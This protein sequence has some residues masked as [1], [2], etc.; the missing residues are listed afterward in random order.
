MSK[1]LTPEEKVQVGLS[2]A[3]ILTSLAL[4]SWT[5]GFLGIVVYSL[6]K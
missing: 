6:F 2:I 3:L 1:K 5:L 4:F